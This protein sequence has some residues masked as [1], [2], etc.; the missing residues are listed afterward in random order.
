MEWL[1]VAVGTLAFVI[2]VFL[3]GKDAGKVQ[4][5]NDTTTETIENVAQ[6]KKVADD[7]ASDDIDTVRNRLRD[8]ASK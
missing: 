7:V 8:N 6:A 5:D 1:A 4:A 2:S 3:R